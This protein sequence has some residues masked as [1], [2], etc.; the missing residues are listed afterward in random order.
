MTIYK[1]VTLSPPA[2]GGTLDFTGTNANERILFTDPHNVGFDSADLNLG[3][4]NDLIPA[5]SAG[6]F[7]LATVS[8]GAGDDNVAL[9]GDFVTIHGGGGNDHIEL[10]AD[11]VGT[12]YGDAGNDV[13]YVEGGG[14]GGGAN[15]DGGAGDDKINL[16]AGGRLP[17]ACPGAGRRGAGLGAAGDRARRQDAQAQLRS[18]ERSRRPRT[19]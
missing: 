8:G 11:T 6:Y 2:G 16:R 14:E 7:P 5:S 17:R 3:G 10:R 1:T 18:P 15:A 13:I 9:V 4:G 19:C 12:A